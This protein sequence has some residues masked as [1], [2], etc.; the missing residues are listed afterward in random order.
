MISAI[1]VSCRDEVT[2]AIRRS[3]GD[4]GGVKFCHGTYNFR[5][6]WSN[7]IDTV[8]KD[9]LVLEIYNYGEGRNYL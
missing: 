1:C 9:N 7:A 4:N 5:G 8:L 6:S 2:N 3:L